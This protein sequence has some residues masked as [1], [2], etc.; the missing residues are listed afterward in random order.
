MAAVFVKQRSSELLLLSPQIIA[1]QIFFLLQKH[2]DR[3]FYQ[4]LD[5]F[6]RE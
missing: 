3:I 6:S 5:K 4:S 1:K 2:F